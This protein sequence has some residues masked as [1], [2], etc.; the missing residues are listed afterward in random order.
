MKHRIGNI[1]RRIQPEEAIDRRRLSSQV[2]FAEQLRVEAERERLRRER[3]KL[4]AGSA[5]LVSNP[6]LLKG[7][8]PPKH[9]PVYGRMFR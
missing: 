4:L 3:A 1:L 7:H 6:S 9:K 8:T 5:A 2:R